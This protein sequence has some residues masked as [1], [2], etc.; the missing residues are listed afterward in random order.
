[1][2]P[3]KNYYEFKEIIENVIVNINLQI[4]A[5]FHDK[6]PKAHISS[7]CIL[8][9]STDS[10]STSTHNPEYWSSPS[11]PAPSTLA[12]P[13]TTYSPASLITLEGCKFYSGGGVGRVRLPCQNPQAG[14]LLKSKGQTQTAR[15]AAVR[16]YC[17][18]LITAAILTLV[19]PLVWCDSRLSTAELT[20]CQVFRS[21]AVYKGNSGRFTIKISTCCWEIFCLYL[22]EF[23]CHKSKS[24]LPG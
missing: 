16:I 11:L 1:M 14:F 24:I 2:L 19:R 4:D 12:S 20:A 17:C 23:L 21:Y 10:C 18:S 15:L 9:D 8:L 3:Y 22:T 7:K 5:Y 13:P 6:D